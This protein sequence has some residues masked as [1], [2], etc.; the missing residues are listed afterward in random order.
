MKIVE[1]IDIPLL[2]EKAVR[3][4]MKVDLSGKRYGFYISYN[5]RQDAW[6]MSILDAGG[7]LLLAG[8]RLVPGVYFLEKYRA[9]VPELPPGRMWLLDTKGNLGSAE[10]TRDNLHTRYVLKYTIFEE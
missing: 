8:I 4:E 9:S 1:S 10:V 2:S 7:K 5:T 3:W 6:F